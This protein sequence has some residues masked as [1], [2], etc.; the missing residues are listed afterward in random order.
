MLNTLLAPENMSKTPSYIVCFLVNRNKERDETKHSGK[1][2]EDKAHYPEES[3]GDAM[4]GKVC[5]LDA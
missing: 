2:W 5:R 4:L 3:S 1:C